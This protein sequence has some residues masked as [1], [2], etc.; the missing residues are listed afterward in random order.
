MYSE[1]CVNPRTRART[2]KTYPSTWQYPTQ[3]PSI[4]N[5]LCTRSIVLV[6]TVLGI[7]STE[8]QRIT[9]TWLQTLCQ[10]FP[11]GRIITFPYR[12]VLSSGTDDISDVTSSTW[13]SLLDQANVLLHELLALRVRRAI[14]SPIIFI[15]SSFGSFI[16]KKVVAMEVGTLEMHADGF[17]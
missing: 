6:P 3:D 10:E 14:Q 12:S 7:T 4:A 11:R 1:L 9:G 15:C 8:A 16:L 2:T 17:Q 13:H 5:W